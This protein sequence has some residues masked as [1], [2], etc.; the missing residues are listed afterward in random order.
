MPDS[1][2]PAGESRASDLVRTT[3]R[4][5]T[6]PVR[7]RNT[8]PSSRNVVVLWT[9]GKDSALALHEVC[10]TGGSVKTLVT[11]APRRGTFRAHPVHVM[12]LQA[13]ALGVR[14]RLF[15]LRPPYRAAYQRVF[16]R[17]LR[18]GITAVVTGDIG[19]IG[20]CA[21]WVR[22]IAEPMGLEVITP[23]WHRSGTG[24][25]RRLR[26]LEFDVVVSYVDTTRLSEDWVGR[27]LDWSAAKDLDMAFRSRGID[28]AGENGEYHTWVLDAPLF[29]TRLS[30]QR[31]SVEHRPK[32]CW[33]RPRCV[34]LASKPPRQ[35]GTKHIG[36]GRRK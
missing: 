1:L 6:M 2:E 32:C 3:S 29:R 4:S 18:E 26:A 23:L 14:H 15:H 36:T 11:F 16:R 9:G 27:R 13:K 24:I 5:P 21:H 35:S 20:N 10:A 34:A 7:S 25:L 31:H 28:P 22:S 8:N 33:L 12:R 19:Q 30:L 17:L